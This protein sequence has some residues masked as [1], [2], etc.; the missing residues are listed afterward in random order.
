[1][2]L[3]V[4]DKMGHYNLEGLV[5]IG[6]VKSSR[7]AYSDVHIGRI[8]PEIAASSPKKLCPRCRGGI[9]EKHDHRDPVKLKHLKLAIKRMRIHIE[10]RDH[11]KV[12]TVKVVPHAVI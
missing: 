1:M 3:S 8:K 10:R 4:L 7:G 11:A 6:P 12:R 5:E 9:K 2:L